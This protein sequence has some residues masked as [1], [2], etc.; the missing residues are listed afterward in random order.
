MFGVPEAYSANV[1]IDLPEGFNF[2]RAPADGEVKA[3]CLTF[4][5]KVK[6]V[7]HTVNVETK[8]QLLCERIS[9]AEYTAYRNH[10]DDITKM[11][12][13]EVVM[14]PAKATKPV[15]KQANR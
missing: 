13:E 8:G 7:G 3:P 11:L 15:P 9:P 6:V 12:D 4:S 1:S 14:A 2:A 5:R 10:V